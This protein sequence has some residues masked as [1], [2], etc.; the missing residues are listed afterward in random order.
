MNWLKTYESFE[1]EDYSGWGIGQEEVENLFSDLSDSDLIVSIEFK[2]KLLPSQENILGRGGDIKF[3]LVPTI[4]AIV[5]LSY[6][7]GEKFRVIEDIKSIL[8][9]T[10]FNDCIEVAESRLKT[11]GYEMKTPYREMDMIVISF[12]RTNI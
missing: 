4:T 11:K 5:R 3:T 10:L 6:K 8:E 9:S 1:N 2:K 7:A 12:F